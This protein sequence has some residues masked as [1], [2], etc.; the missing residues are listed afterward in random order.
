MFWEGV[1]MN[2]KNTSIRLKEIME[3]RN[4]RQIDILNECSKYCKQYNVKMNKSDI[5]QYVSGK[6]EPNQDKLFIL[7]KSLNVNPGW[8]MGYDVPMEVNHQQ[9]ESSTFKDKQENHIITNYRKLNTEGQNKL[10]D[11]SDDLVSSGRYKKSSS[12]TSEKQA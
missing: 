3:S 6:V 12:K 8:L 10:I 9:A 4:M 7:S 11:Y 2:K 1:G 5:S